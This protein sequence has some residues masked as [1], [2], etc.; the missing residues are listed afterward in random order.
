[1][2]VMFFVYIG[3]PQ[4]TLTPSRDI[5]DN[6]TVQCRPI[7]LTCSTYDLQSLRWFLDGQ[8][9]S[10]FIN[11]LNSLPSVEY[12]QDGINIEVTGAS[13]M[14]SMADAFNSTSVLTTT[15]LALSMLNIRM[16]QCGTMSIRSHMISVD[17]SVQGM[18][19]PLLIR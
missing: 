15:T 3:V 5:T 18:N 17:L 8:Q 16:I 11:N 13:A 4:A 19:G 6:S 2:L 9:V 10:S 7:S 12:D 1:M 14:S